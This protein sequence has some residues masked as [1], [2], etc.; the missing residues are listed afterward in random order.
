M[1][2]SDLEKL[3]R[4]ARVPERPADFW[5]NLPKRVTAKAHWQTRRKKESSAQPRSRTSLAW[6]VCIAA[7]CVLIVLPVWISRNRPVQPAGSQLAQAQKYFREIEQLF[8]NQVR[9]II[10]DDKGPQLVL[11]DQANVPDETPLYLKICGSRGCQQFVTFSGQQIRVNGETCDVLLD[12][13]GN[14]LLVGRQIV[15]SSDSA[16][17]DTGGYR[18]EARRLEHAS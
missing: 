13:E 5:E 6:A 15:W 16:T 17:R 12:A 11:S 14:V 3:L 1:N 4:S 8:P 2:N 9:A 10:I 18:I 7:A